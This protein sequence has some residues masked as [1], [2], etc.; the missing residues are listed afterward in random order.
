ME[1]NYVRTGLSFALCLQMCLGANV[2]IL[3]ANAPTTVDS[4]LVAIDTQG[5]AASLVQ[6]ATPDM[7]GS[8][9]VNI[10]LKDTTN[11]RFRA[12]GLQHHGTSIFPFIKAVSAI[13]TNG[14]ASTVLLDFNT[15]PISITIGQLVDMGDGTVTVPVTF[16][17]GGSFFFVDQIVDLWV[18]SANTGLVAGGELFLA[19]LVQAKSATTFTASFVIPATLASGLFQVGYHAL[20]FRMGTPEIPLL[21]TTSLQQT[22]L[23]LAIGF[24]SA[25]GVQHSAPPRQSIAPAAPGTYRVG[26]DSGG[27][28]VRILE[29]PK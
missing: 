17:G 29:P 20:D 18:S 27:R 22:G 13:Q 16:A 1:L 23:P 15:L 9:T 11:G 6:S 26:V 28:L 7:N 25:I 3:I 21:A 5:S 12:I 8:A 14:G 2:K 4:V 19:S 24:S 10:T